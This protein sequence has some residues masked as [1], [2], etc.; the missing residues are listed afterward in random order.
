MFAPRLCAQQA[1]LVSLEASVL[2]KKQRVGTLSSRPAV[3]PSVDSAPTL[4][5]QD[6]AS[7][8]DVAYNK[9]NNPSIAN[10]CHEITSKSVCRYVEITR[11][12]GERSWF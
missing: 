8:S 6:E 2:Q 5:L 4:F 11:S 12:Q 9:Q 3:T 1:S 10:D 7:F